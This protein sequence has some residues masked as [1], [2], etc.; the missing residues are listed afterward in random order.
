MPYW[1]LT[2]KLKH[3]T[4]RLGEVRAFEDACS[5][6]EDFKEPEEAPLAAFELPTEL[7]SWEEWQARANL[8][9]AVA[10]R[11]I[12]AAARGGR[13][14]LLRIN[15]YRE[16]EEEHANIQT[17]F[18]IRSL[19]PCW[20]GIEEWGGEYQYEPR[21]MRGWAGAAEDLRYRLAHASHWLNIA[22]NPEPRED[23]E[24]TGNDVQQLHSYFEQ[25]DM[26]SSSE[27]ESY[28]CWL[29]ED[30]ELAQQVAAAWNAVVKSGG[31]DRVKCLCKKCKTY[32]GRN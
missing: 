22:S 21:T 3:L 5:G 18:A 10:L 8:N 19:L 27:E 16:V 20:V 24:L 26:P 29:L 31:A 30:A 17:P 12:L 23:R 11:T 15:F 4:F 9:H 13:L 1:R 7:P 28:L 14:R 6:R 32:N 2:S 25:S